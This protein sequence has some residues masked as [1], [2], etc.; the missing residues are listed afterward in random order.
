M[1]QRRCPNIQTCPTCGVMRIHHPGNRLYDCP[2]PVAV[3][4]ALRRFAAANGSRWKAKLC[5]A[6]EKACAGIGDMDERTLLQQARNS[7]GP[8][9]LYKIK[10]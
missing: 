4:D 6:W 1:K 8:R 5:E 9:N 10:L 2:I 3:T 7:I